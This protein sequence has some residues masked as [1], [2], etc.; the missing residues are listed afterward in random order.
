MALFSSSKSVTQT[1]DERFVL[2][3]TTG[4]LAIGQSGDSSVVSSPQSLAVHT[5]P[6]WQIAGMQ[7]QNFDPALIEKAYQSLQSA[8]SSLTQISSDFFKS[9]ESVQKQSGELLQSAGEAA[10]DAAKGSKFDV[11]ELAAW[12]GVL[13]FA[14][15]LM[16][17]K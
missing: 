5:A 8:T 14:Y 10:I 11:T 3:P 17:D 13:S 7:F 4:A 1:F 2:D 15:M 16:R 6:S 9:A 12:A